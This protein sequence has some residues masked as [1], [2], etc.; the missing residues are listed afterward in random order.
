MP[1]NFAALDAAIAALVSQATATEG[2]ESS[3]AAV[4]AGFSVQ[5]QNAV[6]AAL[7]AD[8][9]ADQGSIDAANA[10]IAAVTA[11]FTASAGT[12]GAAISTNP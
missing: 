9:A 10:A 3:A 12:L 7:T 11:R 6:T 8:N 1:A 4:I 2:V 5:V